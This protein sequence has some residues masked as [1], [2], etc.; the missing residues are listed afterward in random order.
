MKIMT[1]PEKIKVLIVA[2]QLPLV[3]G[4][5]VQANRL[6]EKFK[7]EADI[8]VD[9][10]AVNPKF[11]STLQKIKVVRTILTTSKYIFD[12]LK[13]VPR[14]DIIHIFSA[15]YFSFILAPAPA[16]L[17]AKLF[18]K[19]TILN[20]RSGEAENHLKNWPKTAIPI[21]KKVDKIIVPSAYLVDVFGKFG[22]E[23]ES[24]FNSVDREQFVF[25]KR[26]K[27]RPMFLSNRNFEELYNVSCTLRAFQIV[28][29]RFPEAKILIVG[30]GSESD[31]LHALAKDLNLANY[32]FLGRVSQEE[33]IQLYDQC[34]VYLNS[35][36]IDNMPNS[37]IE[38]FASGIPVVSTNAGGIP[39]I[40]EDGKTGIL[41]GIDDHKALAA[42][43]ISLID[44]PQL[45]QQI[46]ENANLECEKYSWAAVKNDWKGVYQMLSDSGGSS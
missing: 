5:A 9:F 38:A 30:D 17:I 24:I 1:P 16:I 22:F 46:V 21:I 39:F 41:V 42:G 20:Y 44:D 25:R 7:V 45:A 34:D 14:Y 4:Q 35:P 31:K 33:M 6:L 36:R 23:A 15:S 11:F 8:Q 12:L 10:Q 40:V 32:E 37:I 3:G 26:E 2:P 13:N 27:L 19:R 18:R 29:S 28:Q 43:A